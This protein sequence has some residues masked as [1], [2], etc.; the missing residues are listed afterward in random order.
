MKQAGVEVDGE[1][2]PG[3]IRKRI[4]IGHA[5]YLKAMLDEKAMEVVGDMEEICSILGNDSQAL[6]VV[7]HQSIAH[8][9]LP[10]GLPPHSHLLGQQTLGHVRESGRPADRPLPPWPWL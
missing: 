4:P 10:P 8:K 1:F 9:M 2:F 6:W 7:L 3:F 5:S